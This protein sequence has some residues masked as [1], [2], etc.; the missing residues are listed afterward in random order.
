MAK[1][2]LSASARD[3]R[4]LHAEGCILYSILVGLFN[5]QLPVVKMHIAVIAFTGS[6][7]PYS[8]YFISR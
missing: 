2:I 6:G 4:H 3:K 1:Y 7:V 5:A 8:K